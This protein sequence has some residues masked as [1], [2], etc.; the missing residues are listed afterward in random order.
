MENEE[1]LNQIST[2]VAPAQAPRKGL[3]SSKFFIVGLIG[4]VG[5]ILITIL[6]AILSGGGGDSAKDLS[7]ALKLHLDATTEAIN[8]YQPQVKSSILR[9]NSASLRSIIANTNNGLTN[10][11]TDKY[12]FKPKE[13]KAKLVDEANMAKDALL[14]ELFDAK[15]TGRLDRTYARKMAYEID[16]ITA[17]E[18]RLINMAKDDILK[19]MLTK[20]YDSLVA[21]Y[22]QFNDF[23]EAK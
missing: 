20:S 6:G 21:L 4:V 22:D 15:I 18:S 8:T 16:I 13:V 17:E 3:F 1:Y 10:Y 11:V 5:F 19:E 7:F 12:A 2:H 14:Q 9:S 23:S